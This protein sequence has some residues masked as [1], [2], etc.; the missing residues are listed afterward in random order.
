MAYVT[1]TPFDRAARRRE[2]G[3]DRYAHAR[4]V[5]AGAGDAVAVHEHGPVGQRIIEAQ[6]GDHVARSPARPSA[7][8]WAAASA[9]AGG[10]R[11]CR[12]RRRVGG[13][14]SGGVQLRSQ[15]SVGRVSEILIHHVGRPRPSRM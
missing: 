2:V 3:G 6:A 14:G 11:V 9:P 5:N 15:F 4:L 12:R 10:P 8:E 1:I 13:V 7:P